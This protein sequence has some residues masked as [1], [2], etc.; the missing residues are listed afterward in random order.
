MHSQIFTKYPSLSENVNF[1]ARTIWLVNFNVLDLRGKN[2]PE[3]NKKRIEK[4][5]EVVAPM[6]NTIFPWWILTRLFQ[7]D[8]AEQLHSNDSEDE[9][10]HCDQ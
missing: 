5:A 2:S 6:D 1:T 7:T 3:Q 4:V 10:E 9:E 8:F